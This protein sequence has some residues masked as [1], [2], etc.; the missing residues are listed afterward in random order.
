MASTAKHR[1]RNITTSVILFLA[2]IALVVTGFGTGGFG[3]IDSLISGQATGST[4][5]TVDRRKLPE[6]ELTDTINRQY[7]QARQRQPSLDLA[8]FLGNGAF[9]QIVGQMI[10]NL[11]VQ[12]FGEQ[13]G[14]TVS[15]RMIDREIV[16]IP[17][18]RGVTGQFDETTMRLALQSQ[19]VTEQQLREDIAQQLMQR[20]LLGPIVLAPHV[21]DGVAREY[22]NLLLERR[23]GS[24]GVVPT[25]ILVGSIAPTDAQVTAYYNQHRDRFVIPERRV[26]QY[27]VVSRDQAAQQA[28]ATDAEIQAYYQ[29]HSATYGA[30]ETRT[31][32][33][34]VLPTQ[35]AAQAF[36]QRLRG[37]TGFVDAARAAGFQESDVTFSN[38][39]R[40]QFTTAT[41]ANVAQA[42]FGA[43]RGAVVGPVRSPLGF[44]VIEVAAIDG[45]AA[46]PLASVRDEIVAAIRE[47]KANDAFTAIVNRIQDQISDGA[48]L[49]EIAQGAQLQIVTTPPLTQ[50]G[51]SPDEPYTVSDDLR[52]LLGPAFEIDAEQP[53]PVVEPITENQRYALLGI[54]RV[55]AAAPPPLARI[56]A[57][58][59]AAAAHDMALQRARQIAQGIADA[60]N[61]GTAP[62]Q[63]FAA[64]RP[65][66]PPPRA[67]DMRRIDLGRG[68][69]QV[70]PPLLTLFSLPEHRARLVPAEN[71]QGWYVVY[72]A[73]RTAGDASG[74]P[75]LVTV[76]RSQFN[77]TASDELAQ[78]FA[79][80]I[81][82][83]SR[84][85]R[86]E[87]EIGAVRSRMLGATA[88]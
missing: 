15:Q 48:S 8:T 67:I 10:V 47:Q 87:A 70:P 63:A 25:Q 52:P 73:E 69:Q 88:E 60:I 5:A 39:T 75:Q 43:A 65:A 55:I 23:R 84:I 82:L 4:I 42:A 45:T 66:M 71:G 50:S 86:N 41:A 54:G 57:Q 27:A 80:A 51:T 21:P 49:T 18:F 79:R 58:V 61:H 3:S 14:L 77:N 26:I 11:A 16:N 53:E 76:T 12:V 37:G 22:A 19:N 56:Q 74:Q 1:L 85:S 62:A 17:G 38:Q 44:H 46:R 81:E 31:L 72:H 78:Q 9:N 24:I 34:I 30:H 7:N 83:Q 33:A 13:Q 35:Q 20:Q 28:Q 59:R 2:L 29:A 64:A 36:A 40:Q 68:G 32:H 6:Q